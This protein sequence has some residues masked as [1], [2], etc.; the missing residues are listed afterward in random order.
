[1]AKD[2]KI[3]KAKAQTLIVDRIAR[4]YIFFRG[5]GF[6]VEIENFVLRWLSLNIKDCNKDFQNKVL[7]EFLNIMR[8]R[9]VNS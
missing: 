5:L 4:D 7:S 8:K 9:D 1:M 3:W 6:G 2:I